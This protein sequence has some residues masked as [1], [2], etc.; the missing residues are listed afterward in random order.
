MQSVKPGE[1]RF[2][3]LI[4]KLLIFLNSQSANSELKP[5]Q[6]HEARHIKVYLGQK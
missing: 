1:A 4:Y 6:L 2:Q 5:S 3:P